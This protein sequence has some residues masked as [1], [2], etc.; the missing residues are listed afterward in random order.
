MK[1]NQKSKKVQNFIFQNSKKC[2]VLWQIY[3]PLPY[4]LFPPSFFYIFSAGS[5]WEARKD[6]EKRRGEEGRGGGRGGRAEGECIEEKTEIQKG[7]NF[8]FQN[9]KKCMVLWQIYY[10]PPYPL[11]PLLFFYIFSAGSPWEAR[12]DREKRKGEEGRGWDGVGGRRGNV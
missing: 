6:R 2:M 12:K 9:I 1:E 7:Q 10:L 8:I 11:F 4:P 5:P 3:Y